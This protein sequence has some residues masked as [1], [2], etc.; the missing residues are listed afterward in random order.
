MCQIHRWE[1]SLKL[2]EKLPCGCVRNV[3]N[4]FFLRCQTYYKRHTIV[5]NFH[6]LYICLYTRI[7]VY[8]VHAKC[9][10]NIYLHSDILLMFYLHWPV[11]PDVVS[12][13]FLAV[14]HIYIWRNIFVECLWH[15]NDSRSRFLVSHRTQNEHTHRETEAEKTPQKNT[16]YF[17]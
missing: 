3:G 6:T 2:A 11:D 4:A 13:A 7:Y 12:I 14:I 9:Q 8:A 15:E 17:A 5:Y 1:I 10:P 16:V